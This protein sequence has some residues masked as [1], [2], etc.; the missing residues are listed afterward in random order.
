MQET[1]VQT[2]GQE[3]SLEKEVATHPRVLARENP[4]D[5]GAWRATVHRVS[6]KSDST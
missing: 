3:D 1:Q 2:M 4:M 5:G 6:K